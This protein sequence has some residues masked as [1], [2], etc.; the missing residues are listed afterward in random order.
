MKIA[1]TLAIATLCA[2]CSGV[3]ITRVTSADQTLTGVPWNLAMTQFTIS[4]T[5]QVTGCKGGLTGTTTTSAVPKKAPDPQQKYMLDSTGIWATSDLAATMAADGTST[6]LNAAST[7]QTAQAIGTVLSVAAQVAPV[8]LALGPLPAPAPAPGA[9]PAAAPGAAARPEA[10]PCSDKVAATL[11]DMN[12]NGKQ[13]LK[14]QVA[15][16]TQ[17]LALANDEVTLLTAQAQ[18]SPAYK[19][20][21][22]RALGKQAQAQAILNKGQ[23]RFNDD[24]KVISEVISVTWPFRADEFR[25][26]T[27]FV[28]SSETWRKWIKIPS[29]TADADVPDKSSFDL[30]LAIYRASGDGGWVTPLDPAM[31]DTSVGVPARFA[32]PGRLLACSPKAIAGHKDCAPE[33]LDPGWVAPDDRVQTADQAML[34]LGPVINVRAHGGFLKSESAAIGLDASGQPTTIEVKEN[35]SAALTAATALQGVST[36]VAAIPN[37]ISAIKLQRAQALS[38]QLT[39]QIAQIQ[40]QAS[41]PTASATAQAQAQTAYAQAQIALA[42]AQANLQYATPQMAAQAQAA[43]I[44]ALNSL[45]ALQANASDLPQVNAIQD[46]T[47][48]VTAQAAQL[49]AQAAL[50]TAQ[51]ALQ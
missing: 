28:L 2:G 41:L 1:T 21:L 24:M 39:A 7:D 14:K 45:N 18:N 44:T 43:M 5:R 17:R 31:G 15:A 47:T 50:A 20:A 37:A 22:A 34:Q 11:R 42:T 4:I 16:D 48:L 35:A 51:A 32:S 13:S 9:A 8:A 49:N 27:P 23:N 38:A 25:T 3:N 33:N 12:P 19:P 6:G 30:Y 29:G 26:K 46:Q 36:A 40:Y 10:I